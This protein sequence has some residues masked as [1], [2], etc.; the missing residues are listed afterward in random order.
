MIQKKSEI[1]RLSMVL[2]ITLLFSTIMQLFT[3]NIAN[4]ATTKKVTYRDTDAHCPYCTTEDGYGGVCANASQT[5][6]IAKGSYQVEVASKK[7]KAAVWIGMGKELKSASQLT[8]KQ[9]YTIHYAVSGLRGYADLP[10]SPATYDEVKSL[11]KKAKEFTGT[12]PEQ[13]SVYIGEKSGYQDIVLWKVIP[14]GSLKIVKQSSTSKTTGLPNY[15]LKGITFKVYNQS[16][17]KVVGT[18][19]TGSDGKTSSLSLPPGTYYFKESS[20]G[21]SGYKLDATMHKVII[22]SSKTKSVTVKNDPQNGVGYVK[23]SIIGDTDKGELQGFK[24]NFVNLSNNAIKYEGTTDENGEIKISMLAGKYKVTEDIEYNGKN[25]QGYT[26]VTGSGTIEVTPGKTS[27]V[28]KWENELDTTFPVRLNKKVTD[29][30][31]V[32]GFKFQLELVGQNAKEIFETNSEGWITQNGSKDIKSIEGIDVREGDM[33]RATEVEENLER[34]ISPEPQEITVSKEKS[35]TFYF[36]NVAK[37]TE[38]KLKKTSSDGEISG[39]VFS[40]IGKSKWGKETSRLE[41]TDANGNIDFGSVAPGQYIVEEVT[42]DKLKYKNKYVVSGIERPAQIVDVTGDE[43]T[44]VLSFENIRRNITLDTKAHDA[45]TK[46]RISFAG[47]GTKIIDEVAYTDLIPGEEYVL[48]G[49]LVDK[50]SGETLYQ[51][52]EEIST[53]LSFVPETENGKIDMEFQFD[54]SHLEDKAAVIIQQLYFEDKLVAEANDLNDEDETIYFPSICTKAFDKTT[55]EQ[56]SLAGDNVTL[57]DRITY[58]NLIPGKEY[59]AE[60]RLLDSETGQPLCSKGKPITS[61]ITFTPTASEGDVD[62]EFDLDTTDCGGKIGVFVQEI[63]LKGETIAKGDDLSD[64]K[65][66]IYFPTFKTLLA[67]KESG[68]KILQDLNGGKLVDKISYEG[69]MP[70]KTY[71]FEGV[72]VNKATKEELTI[73]GVTDLVPDKSNGQAEVAF[74]LDYKDYHGNELIAFEKLKFNGIELV[75][76]KDI[77]CKDQTVKICQGKTQPPKDIHLK[78]TSVPKT[79][80]TSEVLPWIIVFLG[81]CMILIVC[82]KKKNNRL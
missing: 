26:D 50:N 36:T 5:V 44:I 22:E 74:E 68:E 42:Y 23:K 15:T 27:L 6:G 81:I 59:L 71:T 47:N 1:R 28:L 48:I 49:K 64:D 29:E 40:L 37:E 19:S 77:D 24:F 4:A 72:L 75:E 39:I 79:G 32:E 14:N 46:D 65:E 18:L 67:D 12:I 45:T 62:M 16:Q 31:S 52:E 66:K 35:N 41:E 11:E 69:L 10:S 76:E 53:T 38:I 55:G 51:G 25:Q 73:K 33:V 30:A 56:V 57:V 78:S 54:G 17:S 61:D 34:Y 80:D 2:V 63:K 21:T 43:G 13:L 9:K 20:V 70:G 82:K 3:L 8:K 7:I 60:G 58:S